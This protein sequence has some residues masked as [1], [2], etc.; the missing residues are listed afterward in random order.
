[1]LSLIKKGK[2]LS[3]ST[4]LQREINCGRAPEE[5]YVPPK[6]LVDADSRT[7]FEKTRLL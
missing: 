4:C 3:T 6:N 1:M 7:P 5:A 2:K